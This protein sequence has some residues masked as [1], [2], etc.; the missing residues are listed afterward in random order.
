[1]IENVATQFGFSPQLRAD[2]VRARIFS[3]GTHLMRQIRNLEQ[4][5]FCFCSSSPVRPVRSTISDPIARTRISSSSAVS[6]LLRFAPISCSNC[7]APH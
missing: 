2:R 6:P 5:S 3:T 7:F 4:Q 1:M